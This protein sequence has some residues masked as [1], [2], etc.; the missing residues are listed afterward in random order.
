VKAIR[1]GWI[2]L[3]EEKEKEKKAKEA[4]RWY[5]LWD[6]QKEETEEEAAKK[7]REGLMRA[8]PPKMKLPSHVQSYRPPA[9]YL[10]SAEEQKA[11]EEMDRTDRLTA[12]LPQ[13]FDRLLHVPHY[14]KNIRERFER[15]LDLYLCPRIAAKPLRVPNK[16]ALLPKLPKP[17]ELKPF[18]TTLA[19]QYLGH[20][21]RIK[22]I[23][24]S[25]TGQ[26]LV[27]GG[28]DKTLRVWHVETG[29]CMRVWKFA[30]K[31]FSVSWNPNPELNIIAAAVEDI[32]V[33]LVNPRLG[34]EEQIE[35]MDVAL[36]SRSDS[37]PAENG[38]KWQKMEEKDLF[39]SGV[40]L[41]VTSSKDTKLVTWHGKG[42]YLSSVAPEAGRQSVMIHRL[43]QHQTQ[44]PFKKNKVGGPLFFPALL[45]VPSLLSLSAINSPNSIPLPAFLS[46][47]CLLLLFKKGMVSCVR[48]HP[49]KPL[50]FVAT[51]R[52]IRVYNL[53]KQSLWKKLVPG[54][55]EISSLDIHPQ[56]DNLIMGSYDSRVNWF[57]LDLSVKPYKILRYH[58][59]AVNQVVYHKKYPLFASASDD[60]SLHIFHGMVY[61]DLLENAL[62]VPVNILKGHE[63]T[64]GD[65]V[66]DC[67]FH[68]TQPWVFSAGGDGLINLYSSN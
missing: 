35:A 6:E 32:G 23:S 65:G 3:D 45:A 11:W 49:T 15:C 44:T 22:G 16:E 60:G 24:V 18:P 29:R 17:R 46:P 20:T 25:P 43:S 41:Q 51:A 31:V 19:V 5:L 48:F 61:N 38:V 47:P 55:N 64:R 14:P 8:P 42:D 68:P 57:D 59:E 56:G 34:S 36:T 58:K 52:Y 10:L 50:F 33:V 12:F 62:I 26:W 28:D 53:M 2:K 7:K 30:G 13:S 21:K 9:E 67:I 39:E 40:R 27:S 4:T 54:V 37:S 1:K 63:I 66:T